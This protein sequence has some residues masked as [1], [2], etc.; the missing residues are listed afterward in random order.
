MKWSSVTGLEE[1][2]Y[3]HSVSLINQNLP[4]KDLSDRSRTLQGT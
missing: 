1:Y 4:V 3:L 2:L